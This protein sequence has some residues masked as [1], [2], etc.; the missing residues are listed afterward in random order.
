MPHPSG[1]KS[2]R[3]R[4]DIRAL[5]QRHGSHR[6]FRR[7]RDPCP[8]GRPGWQRPGTP[9]RHRYRHRRWVRR[10]QRQLATGDRGRRSDRYRDCRAVPDVRQGAHPSP[11]ASSL[12]T[13]SENEDGLERGSGREDED[14]QACRFRSNQSPGTARWRTRPQ[15]Q[16]GCHRPH[17]ADRSEP[18]GRCSSDRARSPTI[19]LSRRAGFPTPRVSTVVIAKHNSFRP[20]ERAGRGKAYACACCEVCVCGP[21]PVRGDRPGI[22]R[23]EPFL[24][25]GDS[26]G[27]SGT[28]PT[29]RFLRRASRRFPAPGL[30]G[31]DQLGAVAPGHVPDA[32]LPAVEH[33]RPCGHALPLARRHTE[34]YC[35][36]QYRRKK[37]IRGGQRAGRRRRSRSGRSHCSRTPAPVRSRRSSSSG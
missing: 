10:R 18:R 11:S 9:G 22:H 26:L 20:Q 31:R 4:P 28:R 1:R 30:V 15:G 21:G 16:E 36:V 6:P 37:S 34:G 8:D 12:V 2:A 7:W 14:L 24:D 19:L 27:R 23:L 25:T 3:P 35:P 33:P 17:P 32:L 5:R 13:P 29:M